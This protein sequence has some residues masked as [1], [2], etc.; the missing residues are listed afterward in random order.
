VRV[1]VLG[2]TKF[3]GRHVVESL[4][5]RGHDVT[6]FHRGE[7]GRDLFPDVERVLGDRARDLDRLPAGATWDA[8]VDTCGYVPGDVAASAGAL[9]GRAARYVFVSSISVYDIAQPALDESSP[10]LPLPDGAPRDVMTPPTY[11]PLKRLCELEAIA[12]FG[13]DRTFVVRPGLIVGPYDPTDRFTY[14][15]VRV[16]RGGDVV[17]PDDLDAPVQWIDVRDLAAFIVHAIE[18]GLS[19]AVNA[20]G[21]PV[22]AT[23]GDLLHACRRAAASR[24]L[25]QAQGDTGGDMGG[26]AASARGAARFVRVPVD[27][28]DAN[29]VK[30]W[31]DLPAWVPAGHGAD[32]IARVDPARCVA[33][34]LVHRPLDE[35]VRDTLR[36]AL[37][38]RGDAPLGAG[39]STEREHALLALLAS[40]ADVPR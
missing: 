36:W 26:D 10:M 19:G 32:G 34:G 12:A 24:A 25:R 28:L 8:V 27:V 38:E 35:T 33:L 1:L 40:A 14:W 2:G 5:A 30:P 11:G 15:P 3:L 29:G 9:R 13:E 20:V 21:P 37:E 4:L 31:S 23:L 39:L 6:L 17:V 7:T 16:A 22:R 18:R